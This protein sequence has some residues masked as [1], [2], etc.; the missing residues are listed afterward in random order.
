MADAATLEHWRDVVDR[1]RCG[2]APL[3]E[4]FDL[5]RRVIETT[6]ATPEA[7]AAVRLLLE[8]AMADARTDTRD[9]QVVMLVLKALDRDEVQPRDLL[10][11]R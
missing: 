7:A 4:A 6:P 8:G 9:S 1:L 3:G 5:C 10:P 11:R 2:P